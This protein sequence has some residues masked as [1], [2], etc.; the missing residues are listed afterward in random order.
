MSG[1]LGYMGRE[2]GTIPNQTIPGVS[3]PQTPA[4]GAPRP[5]PAPTP[6][7]Q[8]GPGA[9]SPEQQ[10]PDIDPSRVNPTFA[11]AYRGMPGAQLQ[12]VSPS[13]DT[14][15]QIRAMQT[16]QQLLGRAP[17]S[18]DYSPG[19]AA[20]AGGLQ[21]LGQGGNP[22]S[23]LGGALMG[24]AAEKEAYR[25]DMAKYQKMRAEQQYKSLVDQRDYL[26]KAEEANRQRGK[27][28]WEMGRDVRNYNRDVSKDREGQYEFDQRLGLDAQMQGDRL[29][30]D[31]DRLN[32]ER[33]RY[34]QEGAERRA[35]QGL[36]R[37]HYFDW[38][39]ATNGS[40]DLMKEEKKNQNSMYNKTADSYRT[41]LAG[42]NEVVP[43]LENMKRLLDPEKGEAYKELGDS[44]VSSYLSKLGAQV[45][46]NNPVNYV[47]SAIIGLGRLAHGSGT[48]VWTDTDQQKAE[49]E[50]EGA[51]SRDVMYQRISEKL[52]AIKG[53]EQDQRDLE[54]Y[55]TATGGAATGFDTYRDDVRT[56]R[57]AAG[58]KKVSAS[59]Y[60]DL[61]SSLPPEASDI[62]PLPN[63]KG[64]GVDPNYVYY[65]DDNGEPQIVPFK[66]GR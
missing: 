10:E 52:A 37:T 48:G 54:E 39:R 43:I 63:E 15:A 14:N 66:W 35:V 2:D 9:M 45:S 30:M 49:Q 62:K 3:I 27:D 4:Y 65:V 13:W 19:F 33:G 47:K 51:G 26:L 7:I 38:G 17:E 22:L 24:Y 34:G 40:V 12:S 50:M 59:K 6:Y 60:L 36:P 57:Q 23:M 21:G 58:D 55:Y 46:K 16:D 41:Q 56:F 1:V 61:R 31:Q 32:M 29:R 64:D 25:D 20:F 11:A 5:R 18:E 53:L 44:A 42:K 28:Q 8:F